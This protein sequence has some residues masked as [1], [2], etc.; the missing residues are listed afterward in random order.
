[1]AV[2]ARPVRGDGVKV[3]FGSWPCPRFHT[4]RNSGS[5]P[6]VGVGNQLS[7][8]RCGLHT[9]IELSNEQIQRAIYETIGKGGLAVGECMSVGFLHSLAKLR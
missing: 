7:T 6:Q 4:W 1:V 2:G 3:G 8:N 9:A 5:V